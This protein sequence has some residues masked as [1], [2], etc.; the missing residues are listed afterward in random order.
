MH[1]ES[2]EQGGGINYYGNQIAAQK[3][4]DAVLDGVSS[5]V[6]RPVPERVFAVLFQRVHG[7]RGE[8]GGP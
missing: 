7:F 5:D 6:S 3:Q 1:G 4:P 2:R 8:R